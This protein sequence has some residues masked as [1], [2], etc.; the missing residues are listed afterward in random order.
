MVS[1]AELGYQ[2]LACPA[3]L[4]C[5]YALVQGSPLNS[6]TR[7][8]TTSPVCLSSRRIPPATVAT[9]PLPKLCVASPRSR[10]EPGSF[11]NQDERDASSPSN[12]VSFRRI[13]PAPTLCVLP[14]YRPPHAYCRRAI[15]A[16]RSVASPSTTS[17]CP[18]PASGSST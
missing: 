1:I 3:L 15:S 4:R 10:T 17:T 7:R 9:Q 16:L 13:V 11:I 6:R 12:S 2:T 14:R 5:H 18:A 8:L